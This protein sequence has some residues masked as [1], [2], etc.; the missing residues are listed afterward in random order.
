MFE[1]N[2]L[3]HVAISVTVGVALA[4]FYFG[5]LAWTIGHLKNSRHALQLYFRSLALRLAL[6]VG[7]FYALLVNID[8]TSMAMALL[9]FLITR[10]F[11]TWKVSHL[12]TI[13]LADREV[14]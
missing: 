5:G 11:V 7:V 12:S 9:C 2:V 13:G 3:Q 10:I 4:I 14:N 1:F 6:V 8:A